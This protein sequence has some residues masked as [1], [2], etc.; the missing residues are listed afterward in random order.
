MTAPA[1]N[2]MDIVVV[3][4]VSN[5]ANPYGYLS[6]G[7]LRERRQQN[8]VT[9]SPRRSTSGSLVYATHSIHDVI[10]YEPLIE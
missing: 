9:K 8:R 3:P 2:R 5:F 4:S 6:E 10:E 1:I 7:G